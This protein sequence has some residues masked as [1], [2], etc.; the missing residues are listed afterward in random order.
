MQSENTYMYIFISGREDFLTNPTPEEA[1]AMQGHFNYSRQLSEAGKVRFMGGCTDGSYGIIV[2]EADSPE[3]AEEIYKND[4]V[5]KS[6]VIKS[7]FRRFS[8]AHCS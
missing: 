6:G 2:F 5:V 4:P 8:I 7:D 3:E 1:Q